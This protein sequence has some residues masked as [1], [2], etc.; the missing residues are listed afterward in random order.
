[1]EWCSVA[2][3]IEDLKTLLKGGSDSPGMPDI[4]WAIQAIPDPVV[5]RQIESITG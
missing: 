4:E 3:G 1:M 5:G 2:V